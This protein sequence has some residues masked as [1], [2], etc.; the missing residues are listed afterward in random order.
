[1]IKLAPLAVAVFIM[2]PATNVV[3]QAPAAYHTPNI[4]EVHK[5]KQAAAVKA[6]EARLAEQAHIA[7]HRQDVRKADLDAFHKKEAARHAYEAKH[8]ST[9]PKP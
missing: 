1:M 2:L 7:H 3:A 6:H 8:D 9:P 5:E 4:H